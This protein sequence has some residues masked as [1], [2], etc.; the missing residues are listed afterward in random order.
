MKAQTVGNQE[1][2]HVQDN[3]HLC[4]PQHCSEY[5][6]DCICMS[7]ASQSPDLSYSPLQKKEKGGITLFSGSDFSQMV[8]LFCS[9]NKPPNLLGAE[10]ADNR[11]C[12][13]CRCWSTSH[14]LYT[15]CF[16]YHPAHHPFW[17]GLYSSFSI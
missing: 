1:N 6:S 7:D 10:T 4:N 14:F 17:A 3:S 9:R 13:G 12:R 11:T 2:N 15:R 5:S 8:L 16:I